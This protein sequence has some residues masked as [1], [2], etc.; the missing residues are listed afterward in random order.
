[1]I[2]L[3]I[4][5][6]QEPAHKVLELLTASP[7][8]VNVVHLHGASKKPKGDVILC[9]VAREDASV[10]ISDL[11]EL[12]IPKVGSIAVEHIETS[13]SDAAR[14][15]EKAAAGLPSD[16]VV[17]EEVESRTSEQTE[18]SFSFV[19]FMIAAMQIAAVGIVLDEPILIVGAMVLG[20]EFGPLAAISVA[21]VQR[22]AALAQRSLAALVVGFPIGTISA[23]ATTLFMRWIDEF[24]DNFDETRHPFTDFITDPTFLSF[25]V[26]F[27]AGAAGVLSLTAAKSGALVGVLVSVTTIPAASNIGVAAAYGEWGIAGK[28]ALQLG[29]N[30]AGIV[31]A[32]V[33]TLFIQR[34]YYVARRRKHLMDPV[35][36]EAG[37]PLGRSMRGTTEVPGWEDMQK[38]EP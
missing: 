17:W 30:L 13:I 18:L 16:A 3:R 24:P 22:Q 33:I 27:V 20:P 28:A 11:K 2:H 6:P 19:L 23:F 25:F 21:L 37:L 35:R 36:T 8:V 4:V 12:D 5:A 7:A 26:A 34:R 1:M 15:A 29:I 14:E 9:D 10:I 31:A 32:G 38:K